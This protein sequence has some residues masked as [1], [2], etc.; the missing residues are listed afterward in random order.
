[1]IRGKISWPKSSSIRQYFSLPSNIIYYISKNPSS[2]EVYNKM[3]QCCKYFFERNPIIVVPNMEE[4]TVCLNDASECQKCKKECCIEIDLKKLACKIWFTNQLVIWDPN[5]AEIPPL[6][7]SKIYRTEIQHLE[8]HEK[9]VKYD[10]FKF[11]AFTAKDVYLNNVKMVYENGKDV[12][13]EKILEEIPEV[14][15]FYYYFGENSSK[16]S[17][18]TLMNIIK[19]KNLGNLE[20]FR[21]YNI[22]ET[23][24]VKDLLIFIK[25]L[26]NT[27]IKLHFHRLISLEYRQ[28][29]G[30]LVD[31]LIETRQSNCLLKF[32]WQNNQK[33]KTLENL[34]IK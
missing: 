19:L 14:E 4:N 10:N 18:K 3:I 6:F 29:L 28:Q 1:M 26:K 17:V 21:F 22:F 16:I 12:P 24:N 5:I 25:S 15:Q 13:L 7:L 34:F 11:L 23:L 2:S 9:F 27:K 31:K 32:C 33:F 30:G 20:T 8:I